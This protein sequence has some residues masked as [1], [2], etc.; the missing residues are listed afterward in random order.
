LTL[1]E[2]AVLGC[3]FGLFILKTELQIM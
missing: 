2:T 1:C 3:N